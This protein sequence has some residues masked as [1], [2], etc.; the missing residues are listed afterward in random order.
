MGSRINGLC[1]HETNNTH[2]RTK[3]EKIFFVNGPLEFFLCR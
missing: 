3:N 2:K 1:Y